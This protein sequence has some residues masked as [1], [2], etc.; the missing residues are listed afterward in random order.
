MAEN[1]DVK[2]G[3]AG[4][5]AGTGIGLWKVAEIAKHFDCKLEVDDEPKN[6]FPVGFKFKFNIETL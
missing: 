5:T 3:K 2:G 1:F 6:E 4:A